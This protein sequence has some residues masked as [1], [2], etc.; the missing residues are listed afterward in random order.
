MLIERNSIYQIKFNKP[1][2]TAYGKDSFP[3]QPYEPV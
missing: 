3:G 2:K 1:L